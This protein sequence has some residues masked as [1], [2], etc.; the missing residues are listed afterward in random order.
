[1]VNDGAGRLKCAPL[2]N[3]TDPGEQLAPPVSGI[4][5]RSSMPATKLGGGN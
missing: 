3:T 1:M 5:A 4:E 2:E